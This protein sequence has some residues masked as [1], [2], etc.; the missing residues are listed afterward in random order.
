M[1]ESDTFLETSASA[2]FLSSLARGVVNGWLSDT[3]FGQCIE[4]AWKGLQKVIDSTGVIS[5]VCNGEG[6][7]K[8]GTSCFLNDRIRYYKRR[9]FS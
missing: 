6:R 2:M 7:R 1:N 5:G 8:V 9:K 3:E 4:Q